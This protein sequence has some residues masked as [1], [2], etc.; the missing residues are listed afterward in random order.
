MKGD[1]A[2]AI[3]IQTKAVENAPAEAKDMTLPRRSKST[4]RTASKI[5]SV[6]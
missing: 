6:K 4:R 1:K 5:D 3:E 2:K